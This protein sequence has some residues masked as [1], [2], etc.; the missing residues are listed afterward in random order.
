[1]FRNLRRRIVMEKKT[2]FA[3]V[4]TYVSLLL[5][6]LLFRNT[7]GRF[8]S[9]GICRD[10]RRVNV[11]C[12]GRVVVN[13]HRYSILMT[14]PRAPEKASIIIAV[15]W[16]VGRVFEKKFFFFLEVFILFLNFSSYPPS[17][18]S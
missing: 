15:W 16:F 1:M 10:V 2:R 3:L 4:D 12:G 11:S 9:E 8:Y 7:E 13:T 6:L 18:T 17:K 14:C 5:L